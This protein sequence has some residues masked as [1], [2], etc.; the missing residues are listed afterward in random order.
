M[1]IIAYIA[2]YAAYVCT[3]VQLYLRDSRIRSGVTPE[4]QL[5]HV[6]IKQLYVANQKLVA[7]QL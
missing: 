5:K 6:K 1:C 3:G 4:T 7:I 2:T